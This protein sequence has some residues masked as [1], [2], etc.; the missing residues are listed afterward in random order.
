MTNPDVLQ[1][2]KEAGFI[3]A[4]YGDIYSPYTEDSDLSGLLE[5][6]ANLVAAKEREACAVTAW[7]TGMDLHTKQHDS[8]EI[9]SACAKAIRARSGKVNNGEVK[10]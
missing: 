1:L 2:A 8:R 7:N 3:D 5:R 6:F 9:G 4:G 10:E